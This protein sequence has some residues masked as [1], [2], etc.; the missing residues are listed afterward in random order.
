MHFA[1]TTFC[2]FIAQ[3]TLS[4]LTSISFSR[5]KCRKVYLAYS[6]AHDISQAACRDVKSGFHSARKSRMSGAMGE[7]EQ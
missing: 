2:L 4:T 3:S 1:S 6:I 5:I 7:M